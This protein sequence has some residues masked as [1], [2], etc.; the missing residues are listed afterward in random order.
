MTVTDDEAKAAMCLLA[1][2]NVVG[3][4]SG[5][6]GLA[7]LLR[8]AKEPSMRAAF[9][10]DASSRVLL[11]GTEGATDPDVYRQIVGRTPEEVAG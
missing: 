11:Y 4:E 1:D 7:G 2:L 9:G 3:G 6:A 5:V 10:L 8:A